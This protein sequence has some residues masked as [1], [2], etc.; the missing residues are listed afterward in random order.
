MKELPTWKM[1]KTLTHS[2]GMI[3]INL[4]NDEEYHLNINKRLVNCKGRH[5]NPKIT[6]KWVMKNKEARI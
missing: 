6:D 3:A 5:Y 1:Y 4:N 2:N